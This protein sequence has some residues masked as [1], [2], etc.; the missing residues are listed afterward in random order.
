MN[1]RKEERRSEKFKFSV[2]TQGKQVGAKRLK[3]STAMPP[4]PFTSLPGIISRS[5][6]YRGTPRFLS[7]RET[8]GREVI[9]KKNLGP[10]VHCK[11]V[12]RL[13]RKGREQSLPNSHRFRM[14]HWAA[15]ANNIEERRAVN[16]SDRRGPL[17]IDWPEP[18]LSS[19][20]KCNSIKLC[21]YWFNKNNAPDFFFDQV[22]MK[23]TS[24]I[25]L[26]LI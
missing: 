23:V 5:I 17:L 26:M 8:P 21:D 2:W 24:V 13:A 18:N 3:T 19:S 4:V 16:P 14:R 11:A 6:I 7:L 12:S 1:I 10:V 22:T 25:L 9:V 15:P 20:L